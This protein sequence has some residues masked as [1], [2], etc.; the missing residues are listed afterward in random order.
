MQIQCNFLS[1]SCLHASC[2]FWCDFAEW[3]VCRSQLPRSTLLTPL[4]TALCPPFLSSSSPSPSLIA[5]RRA[6]LPARLS[7]LPWF[8]EAWRSLPARATSVL[9]STYQRSTTLGGSSDNGGA[10]VGGSVDPPIPMIWAL[11]TDGELVVGPS[12]ACIRTLF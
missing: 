2:L 6:A 9:S 11:N 10:G 3:H 4:P 1:A 8:N 12:F 7:G 5:A